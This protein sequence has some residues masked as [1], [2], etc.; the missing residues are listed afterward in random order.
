M[1]E[2]LTKAEDLQE[3]REALGLDDLDVP[4]AAIK[5]GSVLEVAEARLKADV[6]GWDDL[7]DENGD[8]YR[9]RRALVHYVCYLLVP[10]LPLLVKEV[11]SDNKSLSQRFRGLDF[12]DL[13]TQHYGIYRSSLRQLSTYAGAAPDALL[14]VSSPAVDAVTGA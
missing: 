7:D 4:D 3:V 11:D 2:I 5:R 9:F 12:Q 10:R 1:A 13:A 6:P 8:L 14:T